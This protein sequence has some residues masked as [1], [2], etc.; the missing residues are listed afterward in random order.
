MAFLMSTWL[1]I[2]AAAV[3]VFV[4]S[5]I[6]HTVLPY[7]KSD[8]RKVPGGKEDEILDALRRANLP[9]GDYAAPHAGGDAGMKDPVFIAKATKGPLAFF[10]VA[11]GA[12]PSMGP[13]L[14][15]WFVY[16]LVVSGVSAYLTWRLSGPAAPFTRVFHLGLVLTFLSYAMALPAASIWYRKSWATTLKSMFDG[17][18]YGLVTG[19]AFGYLWPK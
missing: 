9:P 6:T 17:V 5:F 15:L 7:H 16:C 1:P 19:A 12:A 13:Y 11:P 4:A 3:G 2:L 10:T 8:M 14:G 18:L